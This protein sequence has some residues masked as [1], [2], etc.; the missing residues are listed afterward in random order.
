MKKF[1]IKLLGGYTADEIDSTSMSDEEVK[2]RTIERDTIGVLRVLRKCGF[3]TVVLIKHKENADERNLWF[4]K[5]AM[6]ILGYNL[7]DFTQ[8]QYEL[9]S[10]IMPDGIP[11]FFTKEAAEK[12]DLDFNTMYN[13]LI[14]ASDLKAS[15][16][17]TDKEFFDLLD[18]DHLLVPREMI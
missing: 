1:I 12:M 15:I 4:F 3:Y 8:E 5:A 2:K 11:L 16:E 17:H 14:F 10:S 18:K 6:E 9:I 7:E 13:V